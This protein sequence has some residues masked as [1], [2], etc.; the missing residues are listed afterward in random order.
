MGWTAIRAEWVAALSFPFTRSAGTA[1]INTPGTGNLVSPGLPTRAPSA[2]KASDGFMSIPDPYA[3]GAHP[4]PP[5]PSIF[6]AQAGGGGGGGDGGGAV[7]EAGGDGGVDDE[8]QRSRPETYIQDRDHN[9]SDGSSLPAAA[10]SPS[11]SSSSA[12]EAASGGAAA[13]AVEEG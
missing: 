4:R 10:A 13:A 1:P 9:P 8:G 3:G 5:L 11:S 6:E 2:F 12:S 7:E